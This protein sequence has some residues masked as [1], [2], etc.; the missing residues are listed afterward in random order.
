MYSKILFVFVP[1]EKMLKVTLL[2][3]FAMTSFILIK[4]SNILI[5]TIQYITDVGTPR[6]RCIPIYCM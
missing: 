6:R 2:P 3:T 4:K 1:N 5:Y